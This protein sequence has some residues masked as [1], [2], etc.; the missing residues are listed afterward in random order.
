MHGHILSVPMCPSFLY[1]PRPAC[2]REHWVR[3]RKRSVQILRESLVWPV[4]VASERQGSK[5]VIKV[6]GRQPVLRISPE[7]ISKT[8]AWSRTRW[9]TRNRS[10][11]NEACWPD[12]RLQIWAEISSKNP[13]LRRPR[14]WL[15]NARASR[16]EYNARDVVC[17]GLASVACL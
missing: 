9:E 7:N 11:D 4:H 10:T 12:A 8:P 16:M 13:V 6:L 2:A 17:Q 5:Y 1:G 15:T 3:H 14:S